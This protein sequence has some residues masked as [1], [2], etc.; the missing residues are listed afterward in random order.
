M[1]RLLHLRAARAGHFEGVLRRARS[2]RR[3]DRRARPVRRRLRLPAIGSDPVRRARRPHRP[4]GDL[5]HDGQSD[6]RR[7]LHHRPL[8]DLRAG[9][10]RRSDPPHPDAHHPGH[11]ARRRIW[12]RGDLRRGVCRSR[13]PRLFDRLDSVDRRLRADRRAGDHLLHPHRHGRRGLH[14]LGLANPLS[15]LGRAPGHLGVAA[16]QARRKPRLRRAQGT[17]PGDQG[18]ASRGVHP[19]PEPEARAD[20]LF[21]HHVRAGG[22]LVLRL[23][24]HPDIP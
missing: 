4:Q 12:G 13:P 5:P 7:D 22:S 14:R 18:A 24:L 2:H 17:G 1:V 16:H 6:G 8:A 3:A 11:R 19:G 20:R 10:D 23:L 15:C 21:R 9:R